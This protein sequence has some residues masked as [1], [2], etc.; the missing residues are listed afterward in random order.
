MQHIATLTLSCDPVLAE[1]PRPRPPQGIL[2]CLK[3]K[4]KQP[5]NIGK[6]VRLNGW[7]LKPWEYTVNLRAFGYGSGVSL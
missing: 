7:E 4:Q 3:A 6:Q 5:E 1:S 2:R